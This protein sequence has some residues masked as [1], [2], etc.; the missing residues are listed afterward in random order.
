MRILAWVLLVLLLSGGQMGLNSGACDEDEV[1]LCNKGIE[2]YLSGDYVVAKEYFIQAAQHKNEEAE[3]YLGLLYYF[4]DG[5]KQDYGVARFWFE[6]SADSEYA[7]AQFY[8]GILY[9]FGY[10]V[11]QDYSEA[12]KWYQL[13][14]KQDDPDA[15]YNLG[16]M[17]EMGWGTDMNMCE[18][19]RLYKLSAEQGH[20]PSISKIQELESRQ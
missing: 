12:F 10:G 2:H 8:L 6:Q 5:I 11:E 3:Y 15:L 4:G 14:A 18:A 20:F 19:L 1:W 16:V 17:Y 9:T 13:A 7:K